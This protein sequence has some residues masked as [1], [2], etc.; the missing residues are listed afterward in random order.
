MAHPAIAVAEVVQK[1]GA[2]KEVEA[3]QAEVSKEVGK[4]V[5]REIEKEIGKDAFSELPQE[6]GEDS[7]KDLPEEIKGDYNDLA[8]ETE[9]HADSEEVV[10]DKVEDSNFDS[11]DKDSIDEGNEDNTEKSDSQE[12][13]NEESD[14][15]NNDISDEPR[16]VITRNQSLEGDRHP[17]TGVRFEKKTV[18][19]PSGEKI[20]GV[21]PEFESVFDAEIPE[22]MYL[23]T[24]K[25]QFKECNKQLYQAIENDPD[26]ASSFSE[27]QLEQIKDGI[28]DGSAPDGYV[29]NHDAECGKI[30]LVDFETH[31]HTGHTG[32]RA[33]WGG[34]EAYR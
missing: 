26:L 20:E 23:K 4:A 7:L 34:G 9:G 6:I 3:I 14:G 2:A 1:A 8:R 18:E 32:G 15:A 17:I 30:Q 29:W 11:S 13:S 12:T 27:E 16:Y 21:F 22:D 10:G 25:E 33:I 24:D 19:L 5:E 28:Q 31:A